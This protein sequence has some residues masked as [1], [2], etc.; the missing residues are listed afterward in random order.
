MLSNNDDDH[1]NDKIA[2][3]QRCKFEES[4]CL[5]GWGA[6][7]K[8][9]GWAAGG[10]CDEGFEFRCCQSESIVQWERVRTTD[11]V[12]YMQAKDECK[13]TQN[14]CLCGFEKVN[15]Y[16]MGVC[17][18]DGAC[19]CC[20]KDPALFKLPEVL[21]AIMNSTECQENMP[22]KNNVGE[23][24]TCLNTL[25]CTAYCVWSEGFKASPCCKENYTAICWNWAPR[26]AK[27][28]LSTQKCYEKPEVLISM[29]Q[30]LDYNKKTDSYCA[31]HAYMI[32]DT[33][34]HTIKEL[35]GE[36]VA[37]SVRVAVTPNIPT[38]LC[39]MV[40]VLFLP[41]YVMVIG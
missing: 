25:S 2:L 34:L 12:K 37:G 23:D 31:S 33:F 22:C 18:D 7:I 6:C 15:H 11:L 36:V 13:D 40:A 1:T 24:T 5:C 10:C 29:V 3:H 28:L 4:N 38:F 21:L 14:M 8:R 20:R 30:V 19:L 17:C 27:L 39:F 26:P 41:V 16:I 32:P 9:Q 35:A